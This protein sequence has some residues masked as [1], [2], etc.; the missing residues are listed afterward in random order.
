M[1]YAKSKKNDI[2]VSYA[3]YD[4]TEGW[5]KNFGKLLENK[6]KRQLK[7]LD[8][9]READVTVWTDASLPSSGALHNRLEQEI[10]KSALLMVIMSEPYLV[11][12]WCRKEGQMFIDCLKGNREMKIFIAEKEKTDRNLWPAYL[13]D[14]SGNALLSKAFYNETHTGKFKTIPMRDQSGDFNSEAGNLMEELCE[15]ICEEL[16]VQNENP[17]IGHH[18]ISKRIFLAL[19]S[20]DESDA[21]NYMQELQKRLGLLDKIEVLEPLIPREFENSLAE[22]LANCDL[23]V[24]IL[25]NQKGAFLS[26]RKTGFVGHQYEEA[27]ARHIPILQWKVPG[28]APVTENH[29]PYHRFLAGL[30]PVGEEGGTLV[31][32]QSL[33]AFLT[34]IKAALMVEKTPPDTGNIGSIRVEIRSLF[35]DRMEASKVGQVIIERSNVW[36]QRRR[37]EKIRIRPIVLYDGAKAEAH[38]QL[39]KLT[40]GTVIVYVRNSEWVDKHE[41]RVSGEANRIAESPNATPHQ[42][43]PNFWP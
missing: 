40:K 20:S 10:T 35:E 9:G 27:L 41:D 22:R 28:L 12:E 34:V 39:A 4:D 37:G 43:M 21:A 19:C 17:S 7:I 36:N 23:F 8:H 6:L 26:D 32:G 31:G 38:D 25:D 5:V 2:F 11:S 13:K 14:K 29:D 3:H 16:Q 24:Q 33:D 18:G 15:S 42:R 30:K 1:P